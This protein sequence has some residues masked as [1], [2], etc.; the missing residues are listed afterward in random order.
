MFTAICRYLT[1]ITFLRAYYYHIE[2]M[3]LVSNTPTLVGK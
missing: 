2:C 3:F 1:G